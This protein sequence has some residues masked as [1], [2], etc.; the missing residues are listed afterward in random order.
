MLAQSQQYTANGN[1]AQSSLNTEDSAL[2]Q[3]QNA[4]QSLRDLALEANN[5]TESRSGSERD[6]HAGRSRSRARLLSL[7]NTQDGSGNYIFGGYRDADAAVCAE[8]DRRHVQRRS[9][10]A[11][12]AD[13]R[14][15]KRVV[16]GDNG[17]LVFN[18]IKTGNGTFN[19]TAAS[20][21]H[22]H[23]HHRRRP[24]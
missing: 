20:R 17:D 18:Q 11:A 24:R 22:G 9:G 8:R 3:V 1:S 21:Q 10:S 16:V 6:R 15:D 14:R 7:A 4:L 13:R 2:T 5:A 23:R 19:V 12:G